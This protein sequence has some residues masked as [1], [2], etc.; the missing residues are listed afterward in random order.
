MGTRGACA[1]QTQS[2]K[3]PRPDCLRNVSMLLSRMMEGTPA[4]FAYRMPA[5]WERHEATWLSWPRREGISLPGAFDPVLSALRE[6]V[7]A[8]IESERV[9]I[10]FRNV[11][12]EAQAME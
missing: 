7:A 4:E 1:P 9:C 2:E 10:N 3:F 11:P 5:E 8:L 6:M 12:H